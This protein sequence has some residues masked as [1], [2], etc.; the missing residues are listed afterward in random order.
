MQQA[1]CYASRGP[2]QLAHTA[3]AHRVCSFAGAKS[4]QGLRQG[5]CGCTVG[6]QQLQKLLPACQCA[7]RDAF[8]SYRLQ[9]GE[10]QRDEAHVNDTPGVPAA[11]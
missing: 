1:A 11:T 5:P 7:A 8:I 3:H 10:V 9:S 4:I 2:T 6:G